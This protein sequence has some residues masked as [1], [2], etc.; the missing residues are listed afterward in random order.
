MTRDHLSSLLALLALAACGNPQ[1]A[2][3]PNAELEVEAPLVPLA[4]G[5]MFVITTT[6]KSSLS[7]VMHELRFN[8]ED[9]GVA[10]VF[11]V[12]GDGT[13]SGLGIT[14]SGGGLELD[15]GGGEAR[16]NMFCTTEG[17]KTTVNIVAD[18][19]AR[20]AIE[21]KKSET[22]EID[23]TFEGVAEDGMDDAPMPDM[24]MPPGDTGDTDDTGMDTGETD[25]GGP[26]PA[27]P[28]HVYAASDLQAQLQGFIYSEDV[29]DDL[30]PAELPAPASVTVAT[31][32]GGGVFTGGDEIVAFRRDRST[33]E[34]TQVG[35]PLPR[36]WAVG[37]MAVSADDDR[38]LVNDNNVT[39]EDITQYAIAGDYAL[40][41]GAAFTAA[42]Y[43]RYMV[44]DP[45]GDFLFASYNIDGGGVVIAEL[46]APSDVPTVTPYDGGWTATGAVELTP[47]GECLYVSASAGLSGSGIYAFEVDGGTLT[48]VGTFP[49]GGQPIVT[50]D[51]AFVVTLVGG[52]SG[53]VDVL[54]RLD[55]CELGEA[56]DSVEA[57]LGAQRYSNLLPHGDGYILFEFNANGEGRAIRVAPDGTLAKGQ[58]LAFPDGS[59]GMVVLPE[60]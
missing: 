53:R 1:A 57:P 58:E 30:V 52:T 2:E 4:P 7:G 42:P 56:I 18:W 26:Q 23:C 9:E 37:V 43:V 48:E 19:A 60:E 44:T 39:Y 49:G 40:T 10:F 31:H 36:G 17:G 54:P 20:S 35:D 38:L 3:N 28:V 24:G 50:P 11:D 51:D 33:G 25:T 45:P 15:P 12:E 47:G 16:W 34:L 21:A 32:D 14:P 6:T 5:E 41:E 46:G 22:V 13:E 59:R 27:G 29:L 8:V 55:G